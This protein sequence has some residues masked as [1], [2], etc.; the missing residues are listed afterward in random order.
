MQSKAGTVKEYLAEL[1]PERREAIE[2]VRKMILKNLPKG[3]EERMQY[4]MIG[5][6]VPLRLYPAG[7]LGD[8]T[9]PLPFAALASQKQYMSVYLMNIYGDKETQKWFE[10]E[11]NAWQKQTN[12]KIDM[13]KSCIRFTTLEYL[14]LKI[15]AKAAGRTSVK[16]FIRLYEQARKK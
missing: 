2:A 7:Y 14:P 3:Y 4:G 13:G 11:I 15:I 5:Y 16:E 9:K 1:A 6:V 8:K 12:K 10:K